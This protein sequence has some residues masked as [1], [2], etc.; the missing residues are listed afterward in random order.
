MMMRLIGHGSNV[1][2]DG[3]TAEEEAAA[4]GVREVSFEATLVT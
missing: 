1:D 2:G 3:T 4:R